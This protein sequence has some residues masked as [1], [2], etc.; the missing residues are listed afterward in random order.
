MTIAE[1]ARL[2]GVSNTT[3]SFVLNGRA[4]EYRIAE[5]TRRKVLDTAEKYSFKP[6]QLARALRSNRSHSLGLII[7]DPTNYGFAAIARVLEPLCRDAGYQLL[8]ASSDD[9]PE[10]EQTVVRSLLDRQIDGLITAS[11][12]TDDTFYQQIVRQCPVVQLDRHIAGSRI[13]SVITDARKAT[14]DL[15]KKM[16]QDCDELAYIGGLLELSPSRHRLQGYR[17]GLTRAGLPVQELLIC[18]WDFQPDSGYTLMKQ[19]C[20]QLGRLPKG[21][22]CASFSL[23]QGVLRYLKEHSAMDSGMRLGSFDDHE[24]LDYIPVAVDS[25]S[26]DCES[27]AAHSFQMIR[28]LLDGQSLDAPELALPARVHWRSP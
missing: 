9:N 10:K 12:L 16:A 26:Q 13:P 22:F 11:A 24:L 17:D 28:T 23:L 25:I 3:A 21:L 19:L 27:L 18:H 4:D 14:A 5:E 6:S 20:D 7:P 15:V 1:L 2:A 8:I